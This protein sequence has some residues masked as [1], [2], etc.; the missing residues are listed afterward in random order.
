MLT[1]GF[2]II[3]TAQISGIIATGVS[4][5]DTL[6]YV[7]DFINN[8]NSILRFYDVTDF[9]PP[10]VTYVNGSAQASI[11]GGPFSLAAPNQVGG[12]LEWSC[13]NG[14]SAALPNPCTLYP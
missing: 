7:L 8:G 5:G 12:T 11:D 1:T 13:I 6:T 4:I 9:L 2:D 14:N 3:K 10:T